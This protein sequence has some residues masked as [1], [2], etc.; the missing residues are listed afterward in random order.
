M[1]DPKI[2]NHEF[3]S[4]FSELLDSLTVAQICSVPGVV[5]LLREE[6]NNDVIRMI[7]GDE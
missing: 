5:E 4:A 2:L 6:F 3:D 7:R 1:D